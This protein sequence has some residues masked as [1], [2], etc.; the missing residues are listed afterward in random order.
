MNFISLNRLTGR[1]KVAHCGL[2]NSFLDT[3]TAFLYSKKYKQSHK[4]QSL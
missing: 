1:G 3:F 2:V 4:I